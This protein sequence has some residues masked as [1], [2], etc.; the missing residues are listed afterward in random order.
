MLAKLN[1]YILIII[2]NLALC[3]ET[4]YNGYI[5]GWP[6]NKLQNFEN[7]SNLNP[8]CPGDIGCVCEID[9]DC[10]NDNCYKI[11]RELHGQFFVLIRS[12]S[13][14]SSRNMKG[15]VV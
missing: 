11:I 7:A 9:N 14:E 4:K 10:S 13:K 3:S 5:G 6:K 2:I 8:D 1:S 15:W 12:G